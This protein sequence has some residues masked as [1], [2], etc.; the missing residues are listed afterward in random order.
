MFGSVYRKLHAG[1]WFDNTYGLFG[2]VNLFI[3]RSMKHTVCVLKII[4]Y[5]KRMIASFCTYNT[6]AMCLYVWSVYDVNTLM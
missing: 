6:S 1:E 2:S 5:N 3:L 4:E